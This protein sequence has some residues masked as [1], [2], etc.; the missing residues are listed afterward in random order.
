MS[1]SLNPK[2][3]LMPQ[4]VQAAH[5]QLGRAASGLEVEASLEPVAVHEAR[6]AIKKARAV[7]RLGR[8]ALGTEQA[9]RMERQLG[10]L[11]RQLG[12]WRDADALAETVARLK[13]VAPPVDPL[14]L[15]TFDAV[16]SRVERRR[17]ELRLRL[18]S[19][20]LMCRRGVLKGLAD[21]RAALVQWPL[22]EAA[23][24]DLARG[25]KKS[26]KR[27]RAAYVVA[28]QTGDPELLH[29]WRKRTK[30]L[31]NVARLF[32]KTWPEFQGARRDRLSRL[33]DA[34]GHEHDLALLDAFV[35]REPE[36]WPVATDV[37]AFRARIATERA[38]LREEAFRL[39]KK[40]M[41]KK[42]QPRRAKRILEDVYR[43]RPVYE[44]QTLSALR[45][46]LA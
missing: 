12:R 5:E 2:N 14:L 26:F 35:A 23:Q 19:E 13:D 18:V 44:G 42:H 6:K 40:T 7:L 36:S 32:G 37:A 4:L 38:A 22:P 30:V 15:P 27:A 1:F 43:A 3:A 33:A 25:V 20:G 9:V 10:D 17:D 11:A 41:K 45:P 39:A 28:R 34:L 29:D 8:R 16:S 21:A 31:A 24:A 46:Q